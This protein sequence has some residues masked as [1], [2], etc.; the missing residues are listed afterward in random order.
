MYNSKE[1]LKAQIAIDLSRI[2]RENFGSAEGATG[3]KPGVERSGTPGTDLPR[4]DA[5]RDRRSTSIDAN[6]SHIRW[7]RV[8]GHGRSRKRAS[9]RA[10]PDRAGA[11]PLA[12]GRDLHGFPYVDA[13]GA[14]SLDEVDDALRTPTRRYADTVPLAAVPWEAKTGAFAYTSVVDAHL[15]L[16]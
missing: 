2:D 4:R 11:R 8:S 16:Q 5:P 6:K 14:A 10:T 13:S 15:W 9:R 7:T 12:V 3:L 1:L